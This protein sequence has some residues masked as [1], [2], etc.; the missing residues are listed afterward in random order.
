MIGGADSASLQ[1]CLASIEPVADE[2]II[3]SD[4]VADQS[5]K[6]AAR[7]FHAALIERPFVG[8]AEYHRP[9]CYDK[10][11]GEWILQ[12]DADERLPAHA[13]EAVVEL[14]A[15][16]K[17]DGYHFFWPYPDKDGYIR[18]GPFAKTYKACLFRKKTLYMAGI[19][20]E[21]PRTTGPMK[22]VEVHLLHEPGYDNYTLETFRKKWIPWARLQAGQIRDLEKTPTFGIDRWEKHPLF[23]QYNWIRRN[24]ILWAVK[25]SFWFC[26]IYFARGLLWSGLRSIRIASFEIAY[27]WAV[28]RYML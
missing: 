7:Q 21:Y 22:N 2:I 24:P 4:G 16:A 10:A 28:C 23:A 8:E 12:I 1:R 26:G 5:T 14:T 9:F 15:S 3:V 11:K 6:E 27:I 13:N 17:Y 20:H 19:S 18:I 25:E